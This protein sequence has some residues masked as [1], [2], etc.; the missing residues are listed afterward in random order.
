MAIFKGEVVAIEASFASPPS[1]PVRAWVQPP[2]QSVAGAAITMQRV[3]DTSYTA[4]YL[5]ADH[6]M[7][8]VRIES[9]DPVA[10]EEIVFIAEPK[11]VTKPTA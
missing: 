7:Y 2:R 4:Q 9:E 5:A 11:K 6:G 1:E 3:T 8:R 10:A